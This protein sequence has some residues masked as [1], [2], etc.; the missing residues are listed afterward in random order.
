MRKQHLKTF[1]LLI[2]L[3]CGSGP[4]DARSRRCFLSQVSLPR[5]LPH[6]P[7]RPSS[8]GKDWCRV[9]EPRAV[10]LA[11]PALGVGPLVKAA[12]GIPA[13]EGSKPMRVSVAD[14]GFF[15][16]KGIPLDTGVFFTFLL[17]IVLCCSAGR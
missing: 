5:F 7:A 12:Q 9:Q 17:D 13:T 1:I 8:S 16:G 10:R 4:F 15:Q 14:W 11:Y 2:F 6:W 3:G